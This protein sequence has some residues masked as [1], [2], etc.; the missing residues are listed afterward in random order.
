[1]HLNDLTDLN[2]RVPGV[3]GV[4]VRLLVQLI[5]GPVVVGPSEEGSRLRV[6]ALL[7]V[8]D[9]WSERVAASFWPFF[10]PTAEA[11]FLLV[12]R[13]QILF[14]RERVH[15]LGVSRLVVLHTISSP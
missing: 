2:G 8:G 13:I 9:R 12:L 5:L 4:E 10:G 11:L 15:P 1:M 3:L 7:V 6:H 14:M